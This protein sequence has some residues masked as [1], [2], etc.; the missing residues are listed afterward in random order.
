MFC[1]ACVPFCARGTLSP[2]MRYG[3]GPATLAGT[4]PLIFR[5][6]CLLSCSDVPQSSLDI[7]VTGTILPA[8]NLFVRLQL[9]ASAPKRVVVS[10]APKLKRTPWPLVRE[11]TIPTEQPPL[12]HEI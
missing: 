6:D 2:D 9:V 7:S 1:G 3:R 5:G 10:A 4:R 8:G 12:V 11:R